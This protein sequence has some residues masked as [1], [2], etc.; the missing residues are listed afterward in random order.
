MPIKL[1]VTE[2]DLSC[3]RQ[4][5]RSWADFFVEPLSSAETGIVVRAIA[6]GIALGREQGLE[7]AKSPHDTRNAFCGL[8]HE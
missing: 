3:A 1:P 4:I 6:Q 2:W 8:A 5:H 7:F